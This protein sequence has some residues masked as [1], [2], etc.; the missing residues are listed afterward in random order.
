MEVLQRTQTATRENNFRAYSP[1]SFTEAA[2]RDNQLAQQRLNT[3]LAVNAEIAREKSIVRSERERLEIELMKNPLSTEKAMS[4]FGAMLGLFPPFALFSR[5]VTELLGNANRSDDFWIIPLL[6]FVNLV[7]T[8]TGYFSGKLVGKIVAELEKTSWTG[9]LL[10]L[11]FIGILWG[12]I[13]GATGGIF[14]FVIGA[15]FGAMVAAAVGAV[16]LPAFTVLHRL[17]KKGD[18]IEEKHFFPI[19]LGITCV[20]TAFILGLNIS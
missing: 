8:V 5:F 4:Y 15:F 9:M 14:I 12:I 18:S 16:A 13:T 19:A 20:I 11:P 10:A 2:D 17:L 3:L 1:Q 7:C 6:L